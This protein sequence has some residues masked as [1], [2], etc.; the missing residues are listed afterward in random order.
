MKRI[1]NLLLIIMLIGSCSKPETAKKED[2]GYLLGV[3]SEVTDFSAYR[4]EALRLIKNR[5]E[6]SDFEF[7]TKADFAIT[8]DDMDN[9]AIYLDFTKGTYE[10]EIN[11]QALKDDKLRKPL[12]LTLVLELVRQIGKDSFTKEELEEFMNSKESEYDPENGD[13][14]HKAKGNIDNEPYALIYTVDEEHDGCLKIAGHLKE[15]ENISDITRDIKATIDKEIPKLEEFSCQHHESWR[16]KL[17]DDENMTVDMTTGNLKNVFFDPTDVVFTVYY[18]NKVSSIDEILKGLDVD[19]FTTVV[20]LFYVAQGND[21]LLTPDF[22]N[23]FLYDETGKYDRDAEAGLYKYSDDLSGLKGELA[24]WYFYGLEESLS[25]DTMYS[26]TETQLKE[27]ND[28]GETELYG[29]LFPLS[30]NIEYYDSPLKSKETYLGKLDNDESYQVYGYLACET[31]TSGK[32]KASGWYL[33]E[34]NSE[35]V[36]IADI[37]ELVGFVEIGKY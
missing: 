9:I 10:V 35:L 4:E 3:L 30:K 21:K 6:K 16:I 17:N 34:V 12:D 32:Y 13:L 25:Y 36:W 1:L 33:I 28:W 5:R 15:N 24:Y 23:E 14:I 20:N 7:E 26:F 22:L 37:K 11:E 27:N 19:L 31:F 8:A 18:N 2:R 29:E